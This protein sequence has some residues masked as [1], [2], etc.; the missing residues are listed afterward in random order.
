[1]AGSFGLLARTNNALESHVSGD[2][3]EILSS[4]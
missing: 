3:G 1:M 2:D 4:S